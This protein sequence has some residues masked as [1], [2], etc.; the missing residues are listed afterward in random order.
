MLL[1]S[2]AKM[3]QIES[4][5]SN[6]FECNA[7]CRLSYAK[8]QINIKTIATFVHKNVTNKEQ[9]HYEIVKAPVSRMFHLCNVLQLVIYRFYDGTFPE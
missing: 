2:Y 3:L 9:V 1:L 7:E 6:L 8:I 4:R 5:T